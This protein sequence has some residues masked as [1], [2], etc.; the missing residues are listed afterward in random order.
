MTTNNEDQDF[1]VPSGGAGSTNFKDMYLDIPQGLSTFQIAPGMKGLRQSGKWFQFWATHWGYRAI[2]AKDDKEVSR[3]FMCVLKKDFNTGRVDQACAECDLIR[4]LTD[5]LELERVK[6]KAEGKNKDEIAIATKPIT[7]KLG[8]K[9]HKL[10]IKYYCLARNVATGK[11]GVLRIGSKLKKQIAAKIDEAAKAGKNLLD[12]RACVYWEIER[13][14][15]GFGTEYKASL[16]KEWSEVTRQPQT[17][18]SALTDGDR[19]ALRALP[20]L[21]EIN[22]RNILTPEQIKMLVDSGGDPTVTTRIFGAGTPVQAQENDSESS[23][24][25]Q[26]QASAPVSAASNNPAPVVPTGPAQI[27]PGMSQ[28][29]MLLASGMDPAILDQFFSNPK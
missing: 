23:P 9:G 3:P 21:T 22:K 13:T 27:T 2:R 25:P 4:K 29:E 8:M 18:V 15:E 12:P 11:W 10:D 24:E 6:L 20:D 1:G 17:K 7:E 14:G 5:Q 16:A 28:R 26:S 19:E